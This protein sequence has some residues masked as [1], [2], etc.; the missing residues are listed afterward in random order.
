VAAAPTKTS[1]ARRHKTN[2]DGN[3]RNKGGL[4]KCRTRS[5]LVLGSVAD[6]IVVESARRE[7]VAILFWDYCKAGIPLTV[8][9]LL[10]G[11]AWLE[12]IRY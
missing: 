3:S 7:G 10:L 4:C 6:L 1:D 9:T 12:L 8:L 2:S 11:I 5:R